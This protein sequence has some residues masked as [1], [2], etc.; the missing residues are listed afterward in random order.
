MEAAA[1]DV[2]KAL[3]DGDGRCVGGP[4]VEIGDVAAGA[5]LLMDAGDEGM[6]V[7]AAARIGVGAD[8]GDLSETWFSRFRDAGAL[9]GHGEEARA[10]EDAEEF[11]EFGGSLAEWAG[12]GEV[13][14]LDHGGV[15]GG[16]ERAE[17]CAVGQRVGEC[18]SGVSGVSKAEHLVEGAFADEGE[19]GGCGDGSVEE[20]DDGVAGLD[21][22]GECG[23]AFGCGFTDAGERA[24]CGRIAAGAGIADCERR[25]GVAERVVDGVVEER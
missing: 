7:A 3:V 13:G 8:A 11:A 15:V 22:G 10:R 21:E 20:E 16:D 12:F 25:V 14:Q 23:N 5:N 18:L 4:G 6:G 19:A 24:D 1:K 9:A 17:D 2:A